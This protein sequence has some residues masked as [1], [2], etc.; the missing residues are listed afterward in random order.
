MRHSRGPE[1]P[2]HEDAQEKQINGKYVQRLSDEFLNKSFTSEAPENMS[3]S[4]TRH[5]P[6]MLQRTIK[7][8]YCARHVEK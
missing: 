2:Y 4:S 1:E 6:T 5:M 7:G 8:K 3:R